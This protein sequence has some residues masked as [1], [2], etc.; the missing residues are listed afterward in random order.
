[1]II[2]PT[3]QTPDDRHGEELANQYPSLK[4]PGQ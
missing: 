1:L 4:F 2:I 3:K